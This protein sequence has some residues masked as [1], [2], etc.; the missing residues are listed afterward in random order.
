M[1]SHLQALK[2][3]DPAIYNAIIGE[4]KRQFNSV[5]LIPS[6]NYVSDAVLDASGSILTNKYSEGYAK[7]RYYEGQQYIDDIET[8]AIERAKELF[9]AEH[10]NVQPYSGSPANAAVFYALLEKGDKIMG[11]NLLE[12]GHLTHGWKSNMSARFYESVP[13]HVDKDTEMLN[14]DAIAEQV[15]TEK[16]KL[17]IAGY[18]AYPRIIDFARFREI[19]DSVG[20]YLLAD[21]SHINGLIV[22]GVHPNPVPY[23]DVVSST[24]HKAIRGPRGG[25]ILS[26]KEYAK[27]IDSAIIPGLQGGP[28]NHTTA[29]IAVAFKEAM[30][31]EFK[32]Y[33]TQVVANAKHLADKLMEKGFVLV[34]GGT[35]NHLMVINTIA[36]HDVTGKVMSEAMAKAGIVSNYNMVPFDTRSPMDPSGVRLGTPAVTTRGFKEAEMD[37][38]ADWM[39]QVIL[40]PTNED[41]LARI[42]AEVEELCG[43]FPCP[44]IHPTDW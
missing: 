35:D 34:T 40:D 32:Q 28:H 15:K 25:F 2:D 24:S 22:G 41:N 38:I 42:H 16:P 17:I 7:K 10:A 26:K 11:L 31:P 39:H 19:A 20:A 6:E 13:Y 43:K 44:G 30:Q 29:G 5:R 23:A 1:C 14:Y 18:T 4:E 36:S 8:L 21:I 3:F 33:A 12:G 37:M 9:G 27:A